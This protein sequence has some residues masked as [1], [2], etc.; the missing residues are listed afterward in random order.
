MSKFWLMKSEPDDC[1]IDDAL[2]APNATVP[3]TGVRGWQAR[4]LMRDEMQAGDGVLFYHSSCA[5]PGIV[6]IARVASGTRP[7]PTQFDPE[8]PYYDPASKPEHPRWLLLDVQALRKT[9]LLGLPE[10]RATPELADMVVL[11]RGN[12]LSITPVD[13]VHWQLIVDRLLA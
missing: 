3:W 8:S 11:R 5:Q 6:G 1:S 4:N 7:D 2:A 9:R 10:M 13:A 12:R